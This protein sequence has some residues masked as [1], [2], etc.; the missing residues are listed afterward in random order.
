M[1]DR[2]SILKKVRKLLNLADDK[3]NIN[4][5]ASAAQMAQQLI[6]K[7]RIAMAELDV[8]EEGE[9]PVDSFDLIDEDGPKVRV[10]KV[11]L[12]NAIG[13]VNGCAT[14]YRRGSKRSRTKATIDLVG[15][16]DNVNTVRYLFFYLSTTI[17]R[18]CKR[19]GKGLGRVWAQSFRAG[20]V[21]MIGER[22]FEA[23]QKA[24]EDLR[25]KAGESADS[26][27]LVKLETA[28]EKVDNQLQNALDFMRR[29]FHLTDPRASNITIDQLGFDS[30]RKAVK[31]L[32]LDPKRRGK[33]TGG[34]SQLE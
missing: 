26:T 11:D 34:K 12:A 3:A 22:L 8:G 1:K 17:E 30:G 20:A 6:E 13:N 9:D 19:Q 21:S 15:T 4:E 23:K 5:S 24:R 31:N 29:S 25:K 7:H 14:V 33:L 27:A 2:E 18:L 32:P 28:I 10:W 16:K